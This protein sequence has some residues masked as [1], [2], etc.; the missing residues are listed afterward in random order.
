MCCE[1]GLLEAVFLATGRAAN[2]VLRWRYRG[3]PFA[4]RELDGAGSPN[5]FI[6]ALLDRDVLAG[7]L[8]GY[9]AACCG[10]CVDNASDRCDHGGNGLRFR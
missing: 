3:K 7:A 4:F 2:G 8:L 5:E 10:E 1:L 9:P 6:F